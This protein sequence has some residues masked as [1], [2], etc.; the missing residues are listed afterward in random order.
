LQKRN[1]RKI[2]KIQKFSKSAKTL[3]K[4]DF[5]KMNGTALDFLRKFNFEIPEKTEKN[6]V[7]LFLRKIKKCKKVKNEKGTAK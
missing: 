1:F 5:E 2:A 7:A 4:V 6:R 3:K